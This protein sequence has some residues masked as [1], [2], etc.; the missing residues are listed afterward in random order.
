M[1]VRTHADHLEK[2]RRRVGNG[3]NFFWRI[4]RQ[5]RKAQEKLS[6]LQERFFK[7][8]GHRVGTES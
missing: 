4:E 5:Q 3:R 2:C 8:T 6:R 7:L 1:T